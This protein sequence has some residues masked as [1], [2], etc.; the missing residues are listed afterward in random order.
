MATKLVTQKHKLHA[1]RQILESISEVSN[2]AYYVFLSNHIPRT[3]NTV[4]DIT[5]DLNT[6]QFDP[7]RNMQFGKRVAANDAILV[8]KN[9][10]YE[11]NTVYSMYDDQ[12]DELLDSNYFVIVNASSFYHIFK[13]LDNN[14][15]AVSSIQ[16]DFSHI[17]G[18]NTAVYQTSDG[19]RW[20]Y[21]YSVSST[22]KDK[23]ATSVWFPFQANSTV[24]SQS[25]SGAIDIIKV[26]GTGSG[27]HNHL[28]GTFS[29]TDIKV[30]GDS[31]LYKVSNSSV[32]QTNGF[33]TGCLIYLSTGT[34]S[35][36]YTTITDYYVNGNGNFITIEDEFSTSPTNGTTWQINP[37]LSIKG[38]GQD[39]VNAVAR[40]LVNSSSSNSIY[41]IEMLNRGSGYHYAEA[42]IIANSVVNITNPAI[43]RPIKSPFN[44]HGYDAASDLNC[45]G[46]MFSVKFS[47]TESNTIPTYN[48]FQQLGVIKDPI[49]SNVHIQLASSNGI[50]IVD[51]MVHVIKP[52]RVQ[53]NGTVNTT[54]SHL[55]VSAADFE[56]QFIAG[57]YIYLNS[58]NGTAHM[59]TTVRNVINSSTINLSSNGLFACTETKVYHANVTSNGIFTLQINS[60]V[61]AISNVQGV[62][63]SN[64]IFV[65]I[66]SG[67][68]GIVNTTSR[69]GV[70]KNFNTFVQMNKILGTITTGTFTENEYIYQ[71]S[72]LANSNVSARIYSSN[73]SG[74]NIEIYTTNKLGTFTLGTATGASSLASAV[75]ST[76]YEPEIVEGSG[77]IVFIENISPIERQNNQTETIQVTFNF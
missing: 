1:A 9:I 33:Y 16:P 6:S 67:A 42:N 73:I 76:I 72:S 63:Q 25:V 36:Q 43:V 55:T 37:K 53:T 5:E 28:S 40:A 35:G 11:T 12:D 44:G 18:A 27:Y 50:F 7:Y 57:D 24:S 21:M 61:A 71:G 29:S 75:L 70:V 10:P 8:I 22:T 38:N 65:G 69:S 39:I 59:L 32:S 3:S 14:R 46:L 60:T 34:G 13:C 47:N 26:V 52:I 48:I 74:S 66:S 68:K 51:E 54:C 15:G 23:F 4:P 77:E 64:D 62:F 58:S 17:S 45:R 19:Y 20:K 30:G 2:S 56:N 41:R 31:N 49:F